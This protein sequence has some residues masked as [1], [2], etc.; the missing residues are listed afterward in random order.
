[1]VLRSFWHQNWLLAPIFSR[2][3]IFSEP[4]WQF[5]NSNGKK[6]VFDFSKPL[7]D[8]TSRNNTCMC[9]LF[10]KARPAKKKMWYQTS[11]INF[12]VLSG[13]WESKW[14]LPTVETAL[15]PFNRMYFIPQCWEYF[16]ST[17]QMY[18]LPQYQYHFY[19]SDQMYFISSY[20][21]L[22]KYF[23][24]YCHW[25][26]C[27]LN[28]KYFIPECQWYFNGP[29]NSI[30]LTL[31]T[32]YL[33]KKYLMYKVQMTN[34]AHNALPSASNAIKTPLSTNNTEITYQV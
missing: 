3:H 24:L 17:N 18:F 32:K 10:F 33:M 22:P 19:Y 4:T 27:S 30:L 13:Y 5:Q 26:F 12:L 23:I 16:Y 29:N 6:S 8:L 28:H 11:A 7:F 9:Y 20:L 2:I 14:L 25:Y 15:L 21:T 31:P 1:M 34:D